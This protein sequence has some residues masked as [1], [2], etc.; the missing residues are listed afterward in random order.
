MLRNLLLYFCLLITPLCCF[1]QRKEITKAADLVKSGKNLE[2]AEQSMRKL[3][4]DSAN[5]DNEKIWR[6]MFDAMQK[7]YEQGNEK[8]YLKQK[9]DT[10]QLFNIASRMFKDM[11]AFDSIDAKPDAKGRV[12]TKMRKQNSALLNQLRPNLY[13]GGVFFISKKKYDNAYEL[14]DQYIETTT[15]PM[16]GAFHYAEKDKRI[17]EAAY[18]ASYCGY[19]LNNAK[20]ILHHTY[21]ALKDTTHYESML[22]LLTTAYQLDG[23][24]TR[25][26]KT[27]KEGFGTY[28][29]S[30]FFYS[31]LVDFYSANK[32]WEEALALSDKAL[33][34]DSTNLTDDYTRNKIRHRIIPL[35]KELNTSLTATSVSSIDG[36]RDENSYIEAQT[37][38]AEAKCL[39][40]DTL[41]GLSGYDRRYALQLQ[42]AWFLRQHLHFGEPVRNSRGCALSLCGGQKNSR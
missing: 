19:K 26:I 16:F 15:H 6:V 23:D 11:E 39:S 1:A 12:R 31:H 13:N 20:K 42:R 30:P 27:L 34:A 24:S 17:P 9:Y 4:N 41:T 38:I 21:L 33:K 32:Q 36:L 29:R 2:T 35:M 37:D 40:G 10:A 8:L 25:Y 18:W 5:R 3:L 22:Q 7:Q 28:P 14:L